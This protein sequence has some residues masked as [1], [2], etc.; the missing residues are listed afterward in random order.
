MN[1]LGDWMRG[2]ELSIVLQ[3]TDGV[4]PAWP[5]QAPQLCVFNGATLIKRVKMPAASQSQMPGLFRYPLYLGSEFPA[6]GTIAG[7]MQ[8]VYDG[9]VFAEPFS[10]RLI[11][12][13]STTGQIISMTFVRRPSSGVIV[14]QTDAELLM[15][16]TYPRAVR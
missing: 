5:D 10:F 9:G 12:G 6:T 3:A 13:G 16:A 2:Q 4:S 11:P 1:W 15:K 7:F 8:W 14:Y